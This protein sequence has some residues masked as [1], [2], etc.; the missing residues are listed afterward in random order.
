M[1]QLFDRP[2]CEHDPRQNRVDEEDEGVCDSGGDTI[3]AL[4]TSTADCRASRCTTTTGT[5]TEHLFE[6]AFLKAGRMRLPTVPMLGTASSGKERRAPI[7]PN[8][9]SDGLALIDVLLV[10][11]INR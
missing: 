2:W 8:N 9:S 10:V 4:P 11:S 7:S 1:L 3:P 5:E 6:L